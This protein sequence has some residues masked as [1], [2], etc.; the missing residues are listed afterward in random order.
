MFDHLRESFMDGHF[1]LHLDS[2]QKANG[3]YEVS[4]V[5][6][7]GTKISAT[8]RSL[9]EANRRCTDQIRDGVM[10]GSISLGR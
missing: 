10:N 9:P 7:N 1:P 2:T 6:P 3:D 5:A 4:W 8:D